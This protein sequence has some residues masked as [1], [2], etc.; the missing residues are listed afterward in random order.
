VA[1][2][3]SAVRLVLAVGA[4]TAAFQTLY[5]AAVALVGV[6]VA[7]LISLG[8]APLLVA[9]GETVLL[10]VRHGRRVHGAVVVSIGGLALLVAPGGSG[11]DDHWLLGCA[12][13]VLSAAGYAAV[14]LMLRARDD[15]TAG[16]VLTAG[17]FAVG[18]VL[19]APFA[20]T[21]GPAHWSVT[22]LALLLYLGT[23]PSAL[24]YAMFFAALR[25]LPATA[26]AVAVL[27]EPLTAAL[28]AWLVAGERLG[29]LGLAG[30]ALI[31]VAVAA[32]SLRSD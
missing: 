2:S 11:A 22:T 12:L 19:L 20:F 21:G 16:T 8:L 15:A 31:L 1:S 23:V 29:A 13:A 27:L 14:T 17:T 4:G 24:A 7:T 6:S 30:A 10:G 18:A 5:F 3:R 25:T 26:S 28:L 9:G 32:T